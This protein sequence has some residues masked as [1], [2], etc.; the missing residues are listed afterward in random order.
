LES[1][2]NI[3]AIDRLLVF[4][5]GATLASCNYICARTLFFVVEVYKRMSMVFENVVTSIKL[6]MK[7][8]FKRD[9]FILCS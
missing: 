3:G 9:E 7:T 6:V 8:E 4:G 5:L 2:E 1:L